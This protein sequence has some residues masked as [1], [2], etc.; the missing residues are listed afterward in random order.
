MVTEYLP[1]HRLTLCGKSVLFYPNTV[2]CGWVSDSE[3]NK[4]TGFSRLAEQSLSMMN[5]L[6]AMHSLVRNL[7][8]ML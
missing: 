4:W 7:K 8:A 3:K 1:N 5:R 6:K 2:H